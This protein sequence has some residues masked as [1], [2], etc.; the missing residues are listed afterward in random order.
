MMS[1]TLYPY[2]RFSKTRWVDPTRSEGVGESSPGIELGTGPKFG[3][4][5]VWIF[6]H[7]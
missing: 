2:K 7:G 5:N 1:T 4:K 3:D 6:L